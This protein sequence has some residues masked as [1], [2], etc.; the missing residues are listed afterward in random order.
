M[1]G[2]IRGISVTLY[3]RTQ[4]GTDAFSAPVFRETPVEVENVLVTPVA[5]EAVVQDLQ[6]YGKRAAYELCLP[7][8]DT[9]RWDDCRVDFFGQTWRVYTPP[10]EYIEAQLPL[11]WNRKVRV[12]RYG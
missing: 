4:T 3:E 9:H 2:M 10:R 11:D 7:K 1:A 8:G 5:A 12:E 6:L